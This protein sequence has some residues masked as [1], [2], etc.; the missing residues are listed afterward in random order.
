MTTAQAL[1]PWN[2]IHPTAR[3][4][5][6]ILNRDNFFGLEQRC[7]GAGLPL[8]ILV[9]FEG[10]IFRPSFEDPSAAWTAEDVDGHRHRFGM[11]WNR[12]ASL[13]HGWPVLRRHILSHPEAVPD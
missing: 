11:Y 8:S 12:G 3:Y 4:S 9:R 1:I 5:T 2:A 13:Q 6:F 7:S 10:E